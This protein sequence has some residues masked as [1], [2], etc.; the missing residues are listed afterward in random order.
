MVGVGKKHSNPNLRPSGR[1]KEARTVV[2][3]QA[4]VIARLAWL[5]LV[6]SG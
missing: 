2:A 1:K 3:I 5:R 6:L 4:W